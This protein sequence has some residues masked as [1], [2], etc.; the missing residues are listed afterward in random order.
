MNVTSAIFATGMRCADS[1]TIWARRQVTTEPVLLRMI[2]SSRLPSSSSIS[3]TRTRSAA[4]SFW[5]P[6]TARRSNRVT[7]QDGANVA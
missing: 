4:R 5:P 2:R 6:G 1:S 3:R 7:R